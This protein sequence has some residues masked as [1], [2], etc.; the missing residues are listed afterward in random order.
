M[1]TEFWKGKAI[2]RKT[3]SLKLKSCNFPLRPPLLMIRTRTDYVT[4]FIILVHRSLFR[5]S[6]AG[7]SAKAKDSLDG[8]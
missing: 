8:V 1:E 4:A 2:T 5:L 7:D 3:K 6:Q